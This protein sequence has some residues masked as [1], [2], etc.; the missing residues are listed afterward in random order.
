M[1]RAIAMK[2]K[3][4][5]QEPRDGRAVASEIEVILLYADLSGNRAHSGPA[6]G[7]AT[8]PAAEFRRKVIHFHLHVIVFRLV[9]GVPRGLPRNSQ[10]LSKGRAGIIPRSQSCESVMLRAKSNPQK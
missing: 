9:R 6:Y 5:S 4:S 7:V 8:I 10:T 2:G 3:K 1:I